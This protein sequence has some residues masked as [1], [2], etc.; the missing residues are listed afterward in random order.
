M[1]VLQID[2]SSL[3]LN[4]LSFRGGKQSVFGMQNNSTISS[5]REGEIIALKV[6]AL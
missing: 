2:L 1:L 5:E 3:G 4:H 6:S